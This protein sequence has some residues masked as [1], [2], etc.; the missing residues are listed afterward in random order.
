MCWTVIF[1]R[2]FYDCSLRHTPT[3]SLCPCKNVSRNTNAISPPY[4]LLGPIFDIRFNKRQPDAHKPN[5]TGTA[6]S[7]QTK[8]K[9]YVLNATTDQQRVQHSTVVRL[10]LQGGKPLNRSCHIKYGAHH[11]PDHSLAELEVVDVITGRRVEL[12]RYKYLT[13]VFPLL[14]AVPTGLLVGEDGCFRVKGQ[15][16]KST[17]KKYGHQYGPTEDV[18]I[19]TSR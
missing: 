9:A 16:C 14:R 15:H 8:V 4:I 5:R 10:I 17:Y 11:A 3:R 13:R 1:L 7:S 2:Y 12:L 6:S 18:P 19:N